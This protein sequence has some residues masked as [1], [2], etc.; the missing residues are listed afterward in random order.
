MPSLTWGQLLQSITPSFNV[1]GD[2]TR[3]VSSKQTIDMTADD[4]QAHQVRELN[5]K[6]AKQEKQNRVSPFKADTPIEQ[7]AYNAAQWFL[8]NWP[9]EAAKVGAALFVAQR[10]QEILSGQF[11]AKYWTPCEQVA[12]QT[13]RGLPSVDYNA[14]QPPAKFVTPGS[15]NTLCKYSLCE[16]STGNASNAGYTNAYGYFVDLFLK[17]KNYKFKIPAPSDPSTPRPLFTLQDAGYTVAYSHD[18][19]Q[20]FSNLFK[21]SLST[22]Q[23]GF[24][25]ES[26]SVDQRGRF[27]YWS[28]KCPPLDPATLQ[29]TMARRFVVD[30]NYKSWN[31]GYD[32]RQGGFALVQV[33]PAPPRGTYRYKSPSVFVDQSNTVALFV[34]KAENEKD[35]EP[36]KNGFVFEVY[37]GDTVDARVKPG[38]IGNYD[39]PAQIVMLAEDAQDTSQLQSVLKLWRTFRPDDPIPGL[40]ASISRVRFSYSAW[41]AGNPCGPYVVGAAPLF[42][43]RPLMVL[44]EWTMPWYDGDHRS[45]EAI[46]EQD[47]DYY[48]G[49][50]GVGMFAGASGWARRA[51]LTSAAY[52]A[53][54]YHVKIYPDRIT[55]SWVWPTGSGSATIRPGQPLPAIPPRPT[56]P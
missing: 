18:N 20:S 12:E 10:T 49:I 16:P 53:D 9:S 27:F 36:T 35:P 52:W 48:L 47:Y 39:F 17:Q 19:R 29:A 8:D 41:Y 6:K 34:G 54:K 33:A 13:M 40:P 28:K 24:R 4:K 42:G 38:Y 55:I 7:L 23:A 56:P 26:E 43:A 5:K 3:E 15:K 2:W 21:C 37:Q 14:P 22:T 50:G 30:A 11:P 31:D 44:K 45:K 32:D 1:A 46:A 51:C 25:L